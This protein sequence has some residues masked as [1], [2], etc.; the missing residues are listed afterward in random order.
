[1]QSKLNPYIGFNGKAKEA[2]E[3]YKTVFGIF[4]KYKLVIKI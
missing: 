2:M 1:M 4:I 3:F